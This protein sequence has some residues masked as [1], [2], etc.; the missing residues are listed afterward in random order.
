MLINAT[1]INRFL[2]LFDFKRE[3][4][5]TWQRAMG[6]NNARRDGGRVLGV[7]PPGIRRGW[8]VATGLWGVGLVLRG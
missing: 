5:A 6:I 4:P 1:F 2:S 3:L 7:H 8:V